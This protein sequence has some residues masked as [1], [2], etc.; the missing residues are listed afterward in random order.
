MQWGVGSLQA[1]W[2]SAGLRRSMQFFLGFAIGVALARF[3]LPL[4]CPVALPVPL[5]QRLDAAHT[6]HA[7]GTHAAHTRHTRGTLVHMGIRD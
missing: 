6:W 3:I 2:S 7:R 4:L 1:C 5:V